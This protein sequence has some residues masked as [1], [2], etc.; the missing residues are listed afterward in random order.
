M[1]LARIKRMSN[2]T[3]TGIEVRSSLELT[4]FTPTMVWAKIRKT[5]PS[6]K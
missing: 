5:R 2:K 1:K 4:M 6:K 3:R